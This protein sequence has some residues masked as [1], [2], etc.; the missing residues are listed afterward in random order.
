MRCNTDSI[1]PNKCAKSI[2]GIKRAFISYGK[3]YF[4]TES[5]N[6]IDY[7][8]YLSTKYPYQELSINNDSMSITT[9]ISIN[10]E[11]GNTSYTTNILFKQPD[12]LT[13]VI[14]NW[15]N[16]EFS[17][18]VQDYQN[19]Y[20]IVGYDNLCK[21]SAGNVNS[22]TQ[23]S[24]FNG[25]EL[26]Y[27][28][29]DIPVRIISS[30][31]ER[32]ELGGTSWVNMEDLN[33]LYLHGIGTDDENFIKVEGTTFWFD[34]DATRVTENCD[35]STCGATTI[36]IPML[37]TFE[38]YVGEKMGISIADDGQNYYALNDIYIEFEKLLPIIEYFK[39]Q[40]E[41]GVKTLQIKSSTLVLKTSEPFESL[42]GETIQILNSYDDSPIINIKIPQLDNITSIIMDID[43]TLKYNFNNNMCRFVFGLSKNHT[44]N[45]T[46]KQ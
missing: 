45:V 24:D 38:E 35:G 26:T 33:L 1:I 10:E 46:Y 32:D 2:G 3:P 20:Y 23:L 8:Y 25:L 14:S 36:E 29:H 17:L 43:V 40:G 11:I 27:T 28:T 7:I 4:L 18:I 6:S 5:E 31:D 44:V 39:N 19:R 15:G 21:L 16:T 13:D 34:A 42:Q 9:E 30:S 22:G 37:N 12:M 41:T